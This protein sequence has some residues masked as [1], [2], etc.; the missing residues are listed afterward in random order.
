MARPTAFMDI[1]GKLVGRRPDFEF[2]PKIKLNEDNEEE[3]SKPVLEQLKEI[4]L[5]NN[6]ISRVIPNII[7]DLKSKENNFAITTKLT[8]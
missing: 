3:I 2:N 7:K 6:D 8:N 4:Q 1:F 5:T